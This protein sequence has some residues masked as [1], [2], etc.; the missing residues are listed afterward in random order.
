MAGWL[1]SDDVS[2]P[3]NSTYAFVHVHV[4]LWHVLADPTQCG[5]VDRNSVGAC[6]DFCHGC[7]FCFLLESGGMFANIGEFEIGIYARQ[8]Y[9]VIGNI[10]IWTRW[11]MFDSSLSE[12]SLSIPREPFGIE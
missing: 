7:Y 12:P 2:L 1:S 8:W 11:T 6:R 3:L 5:C 9:T 4:G 10:D